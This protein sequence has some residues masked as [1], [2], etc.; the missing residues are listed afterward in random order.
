M[1]VPCSTYLTLTSGDLSRVAY[2]KPH[3]LTSLVDLGER[4][5]SAVEEVRPDT[6]PWVWQ[7]IDLKCDVYKTTSGSYIELNKL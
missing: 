5:Y 4:I 1:S 2:I 3:S 6:L 7:K